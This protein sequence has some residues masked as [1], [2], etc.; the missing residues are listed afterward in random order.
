MAVI[1]LGIIM[2]PITFGLGLVVDTFIEVLIIAFNTFPVMQVLS[3][4]LREGL[5]LLLVQSIEVVLVVEVVE[6][7]AVLAVEVVAKVDKIGN[8]AKKLCFYR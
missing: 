3:K 4:V 1:H 7:V 5:Q 6:A 8:Y 2:A